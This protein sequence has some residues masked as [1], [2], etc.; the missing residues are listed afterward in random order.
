MGRARRGDGDAY[1]GGH[2]Y[3][4]DVD[5]GENRMLVFDGDIESDYF[6]EW[7]PDGSQIV[8]NQGTAQEKYFV[9]VAPA[10]GGHATNIGP[11]MTWDAAALTAFS[12]D[13]SQVIARYRNDG[14][15]WIF[16]ATGG[17]GQRLPATEF[18]ATWQRL[19]R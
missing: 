9:S 14:S 8:F 13:G 6:A 7:S 12:P 18:L 17:P 1:P 10:S 16:P 11:V 3:V 19:P 15:T 5:S 4:V 2:L